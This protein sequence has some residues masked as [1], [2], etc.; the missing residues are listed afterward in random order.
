MTVGCV[1]GKVRRYNGG[2]NWGRSGI[3]GEGSDRRGNK[4]SITMAERMKGKDHTLR[5]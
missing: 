4:D 1:D 3:Q 2:A 5:N